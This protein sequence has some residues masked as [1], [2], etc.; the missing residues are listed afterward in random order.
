LTVS[1]QWLV[2]LNA[3]NKISITMVTVIACADMEAKAA[4]PRFS[5]R[6]FR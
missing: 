2:E 3:V 6:V 5:F 4:M 1:G